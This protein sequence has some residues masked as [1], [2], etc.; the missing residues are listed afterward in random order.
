[1]PA[2]LDRQQAVALGETDRGLGQP[3]A[4]ASARCDRVDAEPANTFRGHLVG[5]DAQYREL[6]CREPAGEG[7]RHRARAG[8]ETAAVSRG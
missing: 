2:L 3:S 7:W 6:A 4:N 8:Q 1:M 5:N